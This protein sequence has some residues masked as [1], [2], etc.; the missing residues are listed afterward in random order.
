M[1]TAEQLTEQLAPT[2]DLRLVP[3]PEAAVTLIPLNRLR[4]SD[5]NPR[6]SFD[7][8]TLIELAI[9]LYHKGVLQNLVARPH[10]TEEGCYELAAGERRH[11]ALMLLAEDLTLE[12]E[13][14]SQD[15]LSIPAD[16]PVPVLVQ[17]LTDAALIE[18]ATT[19]NIQRQDMTPLEEADAF[20]R[21]VAL[22][23]KP[24]EIAAR[25]GYSRKVVEQRLVLAKGL[26]K[27]GRK[28]LENGGLTLSQAQVIAQ[29]SGKMKQHL[30]SLVKSDPSYH[31]ADRL[32]HLLA[33]GRVLVEHA[34]FDV[35]ASGLAVVED[36]WGVS[37][38]TFADS[39]K[40]LVLQVE[41]LEELARQERETGS[42]AF[43]DVFPTET[44]VHWLPWQTYRHHG[45]KELHGL[46]LAYSTKTGAVKRHEGAVR[47]A[48]RKKAEQVERTKRKETSDEPT[49]RRVRD[50][51]HLIGQHARS[52]AL[53][54]RLAEAP[55]RCLALTVQGLFDSGSEVR[56]DARPAPKL[57][58]EPLPEV[59]E[60]VQFWT[61]TRPDLF[62][63]HLPGKLT[64]LLRG[65][66][67]HD[68]LMTLDL[69][70][71]THLLAY[72][73][74]AMLG[75]WD[76]VTDRPRPLA[77]HVAG[78]TKADEV[79]SRNF[80]LTPEFLNVHTVAQLH[81]LITEMPEA[82][83]PAVPV[84][85]TK[86]D[87]IG[88]LLEKAEALREARWVPLLVQFHR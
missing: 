21:L 85:I 75:H 38:A 43:V 42:H 55:K 34:L 79:L 87:L 39:E 16:F 18:V 41:A 63:S 46:V 73:T 65:P 25:F 77:L 72:L 56:V 50:A 62:G 31:T 44:N 60:M 12:D 67:F 51:A 37:P 8:R 45:L 6:R 59:I 22:G 86:K 88:R 36:L 26:G 53:W 83:R 13:D 29:T 54:G 69:E 27:E 14:G 33:E 28:L 76:T 58:G 78:K 20:S 84:N 19:E 57:D 74:H 17:D 47:E 11:R 30:L 15:V 71:L 70:S 49:E 2:A 80:V 5:L 9:D 68:A 4:A 7:H 81:A 82:L 32:R 23:K 61:E 40:A 64:P 24:D 1:S 10:P 48:D 35:E 52:R 3:Q 66:A